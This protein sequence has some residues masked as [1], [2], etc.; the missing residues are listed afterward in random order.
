MARVRGVRSSG[1]LRG[2]TV[3]RPAR[4]L[5]ALADAK[6]RNLRGWTASH[7]LRAGRTSQGMLGGLAN[8]WLPAK[9]GRGR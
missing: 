9:E 1:D 2:S 4:R 6:Q 7:R 3:G 5:R 8:R